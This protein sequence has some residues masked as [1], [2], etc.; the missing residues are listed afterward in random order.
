MENTVTI[1]TTPF[2][3]SGSGEERFYVNGIDFSRAEL[4]S[5]HDAS[6]I[7]VKVYFANGRLYAPAALKEIQAARDA[8]RLSYR[9]AESLVEAWATIK[10][11]IKALY[12]ESKVEAAEEAV[13]APEAAVEAP[14]SAPE[15]VR[16]LTLAVAAEKGYD[17]LEDET[18]E[19]R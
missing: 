17:A 16:A 1:S 12:E 8:F 7:R 4:L 11:E 14:Q 3:V 13:E 5:K 19:E 9:K 6:S 10:E 2:V 15:S 18:Q